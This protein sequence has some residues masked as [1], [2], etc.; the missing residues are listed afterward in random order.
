MAYAVIGGF[1]FIYQ[2]LYCQGS[3]EDDK[4]FGSTRVVRKRQSLSLS[5]NFNVGDSRVTLLF[6]YHVLI[7]CVQATLDAFWLGVCFGRI[8]SNMVCWKYFFGNW[9]IKNFN[10]KISQNQIPYDPK[11]ESILFTD[12]Q[13]FGDWK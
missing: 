1:I 10:P 3:G 6:F 11:L 13:N 8:R 2:P 9:N 12:F 4:S 5:L 7:I